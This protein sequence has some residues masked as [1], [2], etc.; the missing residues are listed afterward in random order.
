MKITNIIVLH[1]LGLS[2][3]LAA[4]S[5]FGQVPGL[6]SHQGKVT[7][8]S[9]NY[10]GTGLFKF[11]FV[12]A[13][14]DT[15]YWSNDGTS[16]GGTE[17]AAAV[18][19]AVAHGVFSVNLGDTTLA[20]MTQTV[21]A[22]AFSTDAAYL[23]VWFN[24]GVNGSQLLT[25]D[26]RITSVAYAL[27]ASTAVSADAV[28]ATAITGTLGLGQL[29]GEVVTNT[30][31]GVTLSGTFTGN[32]AGLTGLPFSALPAVPLTNNQ[33][34]VS[35]GGLTTVSN[36]SVTATNFVNTLIVTNPPALNG[37]AITDLNASQLASGTVPLGRL[38]EAVVTNT[39][40]GITL[41]GTFTGN[42]AGLTNLPAVTAV[43]APPGMVLI[44]VGSFTMGNSIGDSDITDAATVTATVSAFYMDVNLVSSNQWRTIYN[45]ATLVGGY[46]FV[47][48]GLGKAGDHPVQTVD[49][50][51]CV[52]WCNAR[53]EQ[54]GKTPVYYTDEGFA[55]VYRTGQVTVYPNWTNAGYRLPT[56]A[57]WEKAARGGLSGKRFPW[58][59]TISQKLANYYAV[60]ASYSYDLGPDGY[61][62][63]GSVGGTSQ[64][65]SPVGSFAANGYGLNDMAGN[66]SQWCWDWYGSPYAGGT[67]PRGAATGSRRVNR[68]GGWG[69]SADY[70]R[71]AVRNISSPT[72]G[73]L[74]RG[75]RSVLPPG[76]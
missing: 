62:A 18:S 69:Y 32:G 43:A 30:A 58:G 42:G 38:P 71:A 8:G 10:T 76:Q 28:A 5:T 49:W 48:T 64:A 67:D 52:K 51:D 50:Y 21:P 72:D 7:V 26:R 59:D 68:G 4:V 45:W 14:G 25:P 36:L 47:K 1:A 55:T 12:N 23:R 39:A 46:D 63:I 75:F 41:G 15:T 37:S 31:T 66:V 11:A 44:A 73:N 34:D 17:P 70:C 27:K 40:T 19:L 20:N 9:T 53:S 54:A 33:S 29:P 24:D 56:E 35:L 22:S 57:E 74:N 6:I 16:S 13:A 3:A 61:N 60:T 2:L 65:T